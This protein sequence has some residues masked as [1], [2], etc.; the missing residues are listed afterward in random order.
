[1]NSLCT[2]RSVPRRSTGSTTR[3]L[4]YGATGNITGDDFGTGTVYGFT[5]DQNNR[6]VQSTSIAPGQYLRT[7]SYE[8]DFL[9]QRVSKNF[10]NVFDFHYDRAGH[11]LAERIGTSAYFSQYVW[12][13]D[14]PLAFIQFGSID[15]I[16]TDHLGTPQKMT[17]SGQSIVWDGAASDPFMLE[18]L[19]TNL[20]MN[21]RFPGQQFDSETGLHYNGMRDY[22]PTLGRYIESDPIGLA[23]GINTY[24]YVGGN[25][26]TF[27]D[28]DGLLKGLPP[29]PPTPDFDDCEVQLENDLARC[30][31]MNCSRIAY[32]ACAA[33]A[34]QRYAACLTGR[35]GKDLPPPYRPRVIV[36]VPGGM[37]WW[38]PLIFIPFLVGIPA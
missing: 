9:G 21:L 37:P 3:T 7:N 33:Q 23:G 13:D 16:H 6:L 32:Q 2:T 25:P 34:Q 18:P 19:P 8:Q 28:L 20:T 1:M 5:Y 36:P 11:L 17:D 31:G 4:T 26:L 24:A 35:R 38:L 29:N 15:Y 10:G 22:D 30:R 27:V 14:L 12:L